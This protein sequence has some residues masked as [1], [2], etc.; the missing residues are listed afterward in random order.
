MEPRKV[1]NYFTLFTLHMIWLMVRGNISP[2]VI[3]FRFCCVWFFPRQSHIHIR[4]RKHSQNARQLLTPPVLLKSKRFQ[5]FLKTEN[6]KCESYSSL[7]TRDVFHT[8]LWP[9]PP[10]S[11]GL[12]ALQKQDKELVIQ[13]NAIPAV[14]DRKNI[15]FLHM[16]TLG[17][18]LLEFLLLHSW[19]AMSTTKGFLYFLLL[20][21]SCVKS[22][23]KKTVGSSQC[24]QVAITFKRVYPTSSVANY[25]HINA[26][27]M[28]H[29]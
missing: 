11:N 28:S 21:S 25:I 19:F 9:L 3:F 10:S 4:L 12:A 14:S 1:A 8:G 6:F 17:K 27:G 22:I 26:N 20:S 7:S 5:S 23:L 18:M 13:I 15:L 16:A 24:L 29:F 2:N